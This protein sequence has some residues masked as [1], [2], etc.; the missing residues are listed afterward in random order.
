MVL[1]GE[2]VGNPEPPKPSTALGVLLD[3]SSLSVFPFDVLSSAVRVALVAAWPEVVAK[4]FVS[5][6]EKLN[7]AGTSG[8]VWEEEEEKAVVGFTVVVVV[9]EEGR[10]VLPPPKKPPPFPPSAWASAF[11]ASFVLLG[12]KENTAVEEAAPGVTGD[13][14]AEDVVEEPKVHVGD[15]V[16]D[17]GFSAVFVNG[18]PK[19]ND[20]P[21]VGLPVE[22]K[23]SAF[24]PEPSAVVRLAL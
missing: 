12:E 3:G 14:D 18:F 7:R 16:A 23:T 21:L 20:G 24:E 15:D 5:D 8:E 4:V 10:E 6:K 11:G 13:P 22:K 2:D 17:D 9:V 1:A 19:A